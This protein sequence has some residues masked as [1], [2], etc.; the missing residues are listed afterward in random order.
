MNYQTLT[1]QLVE[2]LMEIAPGRV[3]TG[4]DINA[5]YSHDEMPIYG[6]AMPEA[7][8]EAIT[9]EEIAAVMK[10]CSE[11]HIPVTPRGAGT[12]LVG[13][14]VPVCAHPRMHVLRGRH[15]FRRH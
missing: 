1:P 14:A 10:L 11:N 6:K 7:V 3:F 5:D 9:T 2:Q 12:G 4:G 8:V 13:G 15:L